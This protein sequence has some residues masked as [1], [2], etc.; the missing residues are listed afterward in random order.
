MKLKICLLSSNGRNMFKSKA[1][2]APT[3]CTW[4]EPENKQQRQIKRPVNKRKTVICQIYQMMI[5]CIHMTSFL[6]LKEIII[7]PTICSKKSSKNIIYF[8]IFKYNF[9]K[10][11][12][13]LL[14]TY[15]MCLPSMDIL[16]HECSHTL[17]FQ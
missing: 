2:K 16:K 13:Y 4:N 15:I 11:K 12:I 5:H 8:F 1:L 10:D 9:L 6:T 7:Q 17:M 3:P 14:Y